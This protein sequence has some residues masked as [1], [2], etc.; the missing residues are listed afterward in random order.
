MK[1]ILLVFI[2]LLT[3][4]LFGQEKAAIL[5]VNIIRGESTVTPLVDPVSI[6]AI[7]TKELN[8]KGYSVITQ[9]NQ[10]K[11][12]AIN[13]QNSLMVDAFIYQFPADYPSVTLTIRKNNQTIFLEHDSKKLFGDRKSALENLTRNLAEKIP[14][15]ISGSS[16]LSPTLENIIPSHTISIYSATSEILTTGYTSKYVIGKV[17]K[18]GQEL[19][20]IIP[21]AFKSYLSLCLDFNG[22]RKLVKTEP[23]TVDIKVNKLGY[24]QIMNIHLPA[25]VKEKYRQNIIQAINALPLWQV[26]NGE[27]YE[28][29]IKLG[30][31]D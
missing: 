15:S 5:K 21:D 25:T 8:Q 24:T 18:G 20:F 7:L 22:Y 30:I 16:Y 12:T 31:K 2:L 14:S 9:H 19:K 28:G 17:N 11:T 23:I 4:K 27:V 29:T 3:S 10:D 1:S 13:F 26:T 6:E